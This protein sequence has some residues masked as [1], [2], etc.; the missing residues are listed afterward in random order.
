MS[1]NLRVVRVV[2]RRA[3]TPVALAEPEARREAVDAVLPVAQLVAVARAAEL[4]RLVE[5]DHRAVGQ[6]QLVDVVLACGSG[7]T[8]PSACRGARTFCVW[9]SVSLRSRAS[10]VR[11]AWQ[12]EHGYVGRSGSRARRVTPPDAAGGGWSV[13]RRAGSSPMLH[14][15]K[16][17]ARSE[18]ATRALG[19]R[20]PADHR[21]A[22]R[23]THMPSLGRRD[24]RDAKRRAR[25]AAAARG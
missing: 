22:H 13:W 21:A 19:R 9:N 6:V 23:A 25:R 10:G 24:L 18:A 7:S 16:R 1:G 2:A 5:A 20:E 12:R 4:V 11:V 17:S 3:R 8:S 14:D 15:A